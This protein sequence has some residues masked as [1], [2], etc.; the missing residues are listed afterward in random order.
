MRRAV[1]P[2]DEDEYEGDD[3]LKDEAE[4]EARSSLLSGGARDCWS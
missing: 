1:R 2:E 3:A 4:G